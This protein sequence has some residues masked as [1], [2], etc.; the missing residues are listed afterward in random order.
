MIAAANLTKAPPL[1]RADAHRQAAPMRRG[2][3]MD[4][5]VASPPATFA[6]RNIRPKGLTSRETD[7]R[8]PGRAA[9]TADARRWAADAAHAF[10]PWSFLIREK[11]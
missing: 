4:L 6:H 7:G 5:D 9:C 8:A 11:K 2:W 3:G 1:R 10:V